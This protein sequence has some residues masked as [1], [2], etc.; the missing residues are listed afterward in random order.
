MVH[1]N[2]VFILFQMPLGSREILYFIIV[3]KIPY[4]L[5]T[6]HNFYLTGEDIS[7]CQYTMWAVLMLREYTWG[8]QWRQTTLGT[9]FTKKMKCEMASANC[10]GIVPLF[11]LSLVLWIIFIVKSTCTMQRFTIVKCILLIYLL[12]IY[13]FLL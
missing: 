3:S 6:L 10:S 7:G 5:I 12:I 8:K 13:C 1:Y 4:H 2:A 9:S 11:S